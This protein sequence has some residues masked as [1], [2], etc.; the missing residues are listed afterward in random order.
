MKKNH[1]KNKKNVLFNT[2]L[3]KAKDKKKTIFKMFTKIHFSAWTLNVKM[4]IQF[5][6]KRYVNLN[7][8]KRSVQQKSKQLS[9]SMD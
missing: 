3:F 2:Q 4:K 5:E 9:H 6:K 8:Q 1:L 7:L